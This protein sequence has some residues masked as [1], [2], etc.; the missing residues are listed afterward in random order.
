MGPFEGFNGSCDWDEQLSI[1]TARLREF[2]VTTRADKLEN[3]TYL[4]GAYHEEN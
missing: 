1:S 2:S 4:G 3:L